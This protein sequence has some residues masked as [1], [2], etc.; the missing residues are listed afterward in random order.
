[1]NAKLQNGWTW[2]KQTGVHIASGVGTFVGIT[3]IGVMIWAVKTINANEM[4]SIN[5]ERKLEIW[6]NENT[7]QHNVLDRRDQ[8][9]FGKLEKNGIIEKDIT[10]FPLYPTRGM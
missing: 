6:Q 7:M 4:R 10:Q 3:A 8:Y 9:V 2:W 5:N 1:M